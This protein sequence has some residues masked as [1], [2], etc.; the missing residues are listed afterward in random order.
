MGFFFKYSKLIFESLV[1]FMVM[2]V[3]KE[4]FKY[5]YIFK[6]KEVRKIFIK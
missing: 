4:F 1:L 6:F 2:F 5:I 3:F